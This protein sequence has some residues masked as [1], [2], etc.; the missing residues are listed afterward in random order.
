MALYFLE[1][2][3]MEVDCA[4]F[5]PARLSLAALRLAQRLLLLEASPKDGKALQEGPSKLH[6]YR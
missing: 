3:L 2:S 5:E 6:L 1:L 4:H